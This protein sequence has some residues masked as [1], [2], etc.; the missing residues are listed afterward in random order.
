MTPEK[1]QQDIQNILE[2]LTK[3]ET[4]QQNDHNR[5]EESKAAISPLITQ[6]ARLA[7]GLEHLIPQFQGLTE[8][9][10][11]MADGVE[12]KLKNQGERL[13]NVEMDIKSVKQSIEPIGDLDNRVKKIETK[14]AK[15]WESITEKILL[16]AIG[17]VV[18]YFLARFGM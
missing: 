18:M 12:A 8:R 11:K 7:T 13:G 10:D 14:G 1:M 2:R 17:A 3:I 5:I 15:R 6:I 4:R 16:V 9:V